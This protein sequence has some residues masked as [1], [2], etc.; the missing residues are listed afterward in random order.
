MMIAHHIGLH[1]ELNPYWQLILA[2]PVQFFA[3]WAFYRG[4]YRSLKAGSA[5][6][7][8]LVALGT[9]VAYF[10]SLVSLIAGWGLFYF[11]SAAVLMTIILLGKLLEAVAK[12]RTSEAIEKLMGLRAK[13]ARVIRKGKELDIPAEEVVAGDL[14]VVRPGERVPVDGIIREGNTSI[15]ESHLT[16]ESMPVEK[17]PGDDVVGASINKF[18]NLPGA[19]GR[20]DTVLAD[21]PSGRRGRGARRRST[22]GRRVLISLSRS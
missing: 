11:E 19:E 13:T 6:M 17:G 3:G 15:D 4:A 2:T 16:G 12:G 7:D 1:F 18:G 14:I 21:Y 20:E 22:T 5:N 8:V 10:Y 9:S